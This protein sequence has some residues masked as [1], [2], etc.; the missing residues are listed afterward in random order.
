MLAPLAAIAAG[1]VVSR[2]VPFESRE[3]L[4]GIAAFLIL[5]VVSLWRRLRPLALACAM[6][7]L[8]AA[9]ALTDVL[10]RPGPAPEI[11]T[12]ARETLIVSGCVV[13]PPVFSA[14]REQFTLE[15][16]PGARA[17]VSLYLLEGQAAPPLRYGQKVEFDAKLRDL[18]GG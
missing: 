16:E 6:L 11:D 3:L 17:R 8:I 4:S 18:G 2:F 14:E 12:G 1:I 7:A 9:G 10:H 5:G 13:D 15:L